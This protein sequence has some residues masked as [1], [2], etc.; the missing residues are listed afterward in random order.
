MEFIDIKDK[1]TDR[2]VNLSIND[3]GQVYLLGNLPHNTELSIDKD[4]AIE[5]IKLLLPI[6]KPQNENY[7]DDRKRWL[8]SQFEN[9]KNSKIFLEKE[10]GD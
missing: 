6:A 7:S 8:N 10:S 9:L 5:L 2:I 3:K 1:T 4:N